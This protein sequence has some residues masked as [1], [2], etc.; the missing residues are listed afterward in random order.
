MWVYF[1][2]ETHLQENM[3]ETKK[4]CIRGKTHTPMRIRQDCEHTD[5]CFFEC[6]LHVRISDRET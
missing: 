4:S 2:Y 3:D 1:N 6:T 5:T